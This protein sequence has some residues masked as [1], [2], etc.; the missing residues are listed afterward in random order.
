MKTRNI[1]GAALSALTFALA[2][3]MAF[4]LPLMAQRGPRGNGPGPGAGAGLSAQPL[5]PQEVTWLV[6][7]RE[8]EKL[9]RDVYQLLNEKYNLLVFANI[10]ESEERHF[11]AVG[12]LLSRHGIPDPTEGK[13]AGVY[14]DPKLNL[15]YA[16]LIAKGTKSAQDALEVG[17]LIEET[18]IKDLEAAL[19]VAAKPDIKRVF[20]NLLDGSYNHLDAFQMAGEVLCLAAAGN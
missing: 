9:A 12:V 8:E 14:T 1:R 7:M 19:K 11:S 2:L 13:A 4:S 18:D 20:T 15:L 17:L 3:L 6:F 10:A 5:D 16:E